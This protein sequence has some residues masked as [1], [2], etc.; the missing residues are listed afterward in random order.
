MIEVVSRIACSWLPRCRHNS[1]SLLYLTFLSSMYTLCQKSHSMYYNLVLVLT[2]IENLLNY[3][4]W[5]LKQTQSLPDL[6]GRK[7]HVAA[8]TTPYASPIAASNA[9]H[10]AEGL[11]RPYASGTVVLNIKAKQ[12]VIMSL[13]EYKNITCS[14]LNSFT[15][16]RC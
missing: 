1:S 13:I 7:L 3:F 4:P 6:L 9:N 12:I 14:L 11:N 10:H 8:V 16:C 15:I 5:G 2:R